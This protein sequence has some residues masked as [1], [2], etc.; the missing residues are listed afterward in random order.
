MCN[1]FDYH[2]FGRPFIV[3]RLRAGV[4]CQ[5]PRYCLY[6]FN[7]SVIF[8]SNFPREECRL[9]SNI[10]FQTWPYHRPP[11]ALSGDLTYDPFAYDVACMGDM[12]SEAFDVRFTNLFFHQ[13]IWDYQYHI[14]KIP[15]LAPLFDRMTT[16]VIK[17]RFTASQAHEFA[18]MIERDMTPDILNVCFPYAPRHILNT[19]RWKILDASFVKTWSSFRTP[20]MGLWLRFCIWMNTSQTFS[21]PFLRL[22]KFCRLWFQYWGRYPSYYPTEFDGWHP[23]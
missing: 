8:P 19:D 15:L 20:P 3:A 4:F 21:L 1:I 5:P 2:S 7:W 14:E 12:L 6:D 11:D 17:S 23:F 13:L 10:A 16:H 9:S 22:I 18:E